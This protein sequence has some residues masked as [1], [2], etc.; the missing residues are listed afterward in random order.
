MQVTIASRELYCMTSE[1]RELFYLI[2]CASCVSFITMLTDALKISETK[3]LYDL[4]QQLKQKLSS[5]SL[6][7]IEEKKALLFEQS[8]PSL[9]TLLW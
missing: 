7:S 1:Q 4:K 6:L 8:D 2:N 9:N 5:K 3:T